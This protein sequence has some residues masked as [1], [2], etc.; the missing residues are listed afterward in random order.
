MKDIIKNF[1][2]IDDS[3]IQKTESYMAAIQAKISKINAMNFETTT[4]KHAYILT[5]VQKYLKICNFYHQ[6]IGFLFK[7]N[8]CDE[9]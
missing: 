5:E 2:Q 6:L 3:T 4:A 1:F 8:I 9:K 7:C